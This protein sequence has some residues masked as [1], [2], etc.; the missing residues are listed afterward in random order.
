MVAEPMATNAVGRADWHYPCGSE[1]P[2]SDP[3]PFQVAVVD[4]DPAIRRLVRL[5]LK[6]SGYES[7]EFG[8]GGEGRGQLPTIGWARAILDRPLPAREGVVFCNQLKPDPGL[9][10][11]YIIMLT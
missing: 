2:M 6:R 1:N 4:D 5:L 7:V 9:G 10:N 3:Q 11:G 8:M